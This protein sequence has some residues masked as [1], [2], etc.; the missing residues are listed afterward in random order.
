VSAGRARMLVNV[1][2]E[3]EAALGLW[4][5]Y[6]SHCLLAYTGSWSSAQCLGVAAD[7]THRVAAACA[8]SLGDGESG[9]AEHDDGVKPPDAKQRVREQIGAAAALPS[10]LS[11]RHAG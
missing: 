7:A 3:G 11:R 10:A 8:A 9:A 5:G 2:N 4:L 6:G 1:M